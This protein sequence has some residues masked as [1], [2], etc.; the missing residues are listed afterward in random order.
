M[1]EKK[2]YLSGKEIRKMSTDTIIEKIL[3]LPE[4]TKFMLLSPVVFGK[5]G[6]HEKVFDDARKNG[7]VRARVDGYL[8]SL[9]EV[10]ALDKNKK[11]DIEK[12]YYTTLTLA[13]TT[14]TNDSISQ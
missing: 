6:M 10:P 9:D 14:T 1:A 5:K 3:A 4:R 2:H 13:T 8:Y 12:K 7:Y 11:H